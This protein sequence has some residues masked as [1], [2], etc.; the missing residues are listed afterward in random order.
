MIKRL[1][2]VGQNISEENKYKKG[3]PTMCDRENLV[4]CSD[5]DRYHDIGTA[6]HVGLCDN[7]GCFPQFTGLR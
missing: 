7:I 5:R 3:G 1:Y 4:W 2:G 6:A